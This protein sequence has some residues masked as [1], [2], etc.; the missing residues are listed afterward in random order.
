MSQSSGQ[1]YLVR[2]YPNSHRIWLWWAI[3]ETSTSK[4]NRTFQNEALSVLSVPQGVYPIREGS[5]DPSFPRSQIPNIDKLGVEL[6]VSR[7]YQVKNIGL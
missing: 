4:G 6:G 1:G 3:K 2:F 5:E 7:K